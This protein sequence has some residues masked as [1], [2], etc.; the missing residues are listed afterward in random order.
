MTVEREWG[1]GMG[2]IKRWRHI[3][4]LLVLCA[5]VYFPSLQNGYIWDDDQYVYNNPAVTGPGGFD[6]IWF[7]HRM[8]QYYP[9][10]FTLFRIEYMLWGNNPA[11]YHAVSLC[12][13]AANSI[14]L[15]L[16]VG[17]VAPRIAF[18][19]AAMF[20]VHPLQVETVAWITE[21]KNLLSLFFSLAACLC[22]LRFYKEARPVCYLGALLFF[23][24]AM[25]SKSMAAGFAVVP[26]AYAYWKNGK[27]TRGDVAACIPFLFIGIVFGLHTAW[28][29]VNRVGANGHIWSMSPAAHLLLASRIFLFYLY[30]ALVPLEFIF[31]Y[32]RWKIDI[33]SLSDWVFFALVVAIA[34]AAF[35]ARR[36]TNRSGPVLLFL[37]AAMIF[38]ALGF[39]NVY[40]MRFSFVADHFSYLASPVI[41]IMIVAITFYVADGIKKAQLLKKEQE[42]SF[43][44]FCRVVTI[45]IAVG[46]CFESRHLVGNYRNE[47]TLW[48][49]VIEKNR[50]SY[51]AYNNLGAAYGNIGRDREAVACFKKAMDL[52]PDLARHAINLGNALLNIGEPGRA[53]PVLEKAVRIAPQNGQAHHLLAIAYYDVGLFGL[54]RAHYEKAVKLGARVKPELAKAIGRMPGKGR[55]ISTNLLFPSSA[56][57]TLPHLHLFRDIHGR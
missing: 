31:F 18:A 9:L 23:L 40:P 14:L 49:S 20:A 55:R 3:F 15:Y 27:V 29:E 8:P 25:L 53:V 11:G 13:H 44:W 46:L 37:Y 39:F 28:I 36:R 17:N 38:P 6:D 45:A 54:A 41:C 47:I 35:M 50:T 57:P 4:L 30:K 7:S 33:R 51:A 52:R 42:N 56:E 24:C 2:T 16:V 34:A 1:M 32:P 19:A 48:K 43:R 5:A 10:V 12:L 22:L 26:L 21:H